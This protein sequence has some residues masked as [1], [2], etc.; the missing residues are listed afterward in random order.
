VRLWIACSFHRQRQFCW[1]WERPR[2][3]FF[4]YDVAAD[5]RFLVNAFDAP[6]AERPDR[7]TVVLNWMAARPRPEGS[8]QAPKERTGARTHALRSDMHH[9]RTRV[10]GRSNRIG[11]LISE[12]H[13]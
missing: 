4:L 3:S 12:R 7:M 13:Q 10:W 2:S 1:T 9:D 6:D 8:T 11:G 5:G